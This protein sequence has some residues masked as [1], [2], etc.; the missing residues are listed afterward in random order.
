MTKPLMAEFDAAR[1]WTVEF[2][3]PL[4]QA[5]LDFSPIR[6]RWS[7]GEIL[8]HVLRAQ[9]YYQ[10]EIAE[11]VALRRSGRRP[12][13]RRTFRELNLAPRMLP[14]SILPW[15]DWPMRMMNRAVPD[16]VRD[17]LLRFPI[18]P[19]RAAD[20]GL[21]RPGRPAAELRGELLAS[22]AALR[23]LLDAAADLPLGQLVWEHPLIGVAD[24]PRLVKLLARHERRH[25]GQMESVRAERKFPATRSRS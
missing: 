3:A 2:A 7:I 21:P 5:Q 25:Q 18:L 9:R 23:G 4:S 22:A 20:S 6:G 10:D 24:V 14:S 12:Y 15:I 17:L 16:A 8:D 1:A 19:A 13:L 11:L